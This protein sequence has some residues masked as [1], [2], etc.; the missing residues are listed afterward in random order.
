MFVRGVAALIVLPIARKLRAV[1][2]HHSAFAVAQVIIPICL[3]SVGSK[4]KEQRTALVIRAVREDVCASAVA[5]VHS[6]VP[7]VRCAV[8]P[9]ADAAP[10]L[11][12]VAP[13]ALI[14]CARH[15]R[16]Y[17]STV[18][19]VVHPLALVAVA[20]APVLNAEAVRLAFD[21]LPL[22]AITRRP[23][24]DAAAVTL[25]ILPLTFVAIAVGPRLRTVKAPPTDRNPECSKKKGGSE[26]TM[27]FVSTSETVR[28]T[29]N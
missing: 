17:S 24:V 10:V 21:P 18:S 28:N 29:G 23:I 6:P 7:V 4:E 27:I 26:E 20:I 8:T 9:N 2:P 22:I 13:L 11:L 5:E 19:V 25:V 12:T 16:V 14:V 15:P 3:R 1:L